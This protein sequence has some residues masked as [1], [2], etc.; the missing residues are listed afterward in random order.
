MIVLSHSMITANAHTPADNESA[1]KSD[2]AGLE[3]CWLPPKY[4]QIHNR[5][6]EFAGTSRNLRSILR[7]S[8]HGF[9]KSRGSDSA[10]INGI[11]QFTWKYKRALD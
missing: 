10:A 8:R 11:G 1:G 2:N 9:D 3:L 4:D 5:L 7:A 6:T